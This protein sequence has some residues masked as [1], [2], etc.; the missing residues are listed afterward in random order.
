MTIVALGVTVS[1][2]ADGFDLSVG[3]NVGF[4]SM[5][6]TSVMVIHGLPAIAA[7][8]IGLIAGAGIGIFNGLL[9]VKARVP[10]LLATLGT[11]FLFLGL[12][13]IDDLG[14]LDRAGHAHRCPGHARPGQGLARVPVA[15]PRRHLRYPR[16]GRRSWSSSPSR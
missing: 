1:L 5:L 12:T 2:A 7:V 6:T 9:I 13:L 14:H 11:M 16:P 8:A 15:G 3:A 10:D 4:V